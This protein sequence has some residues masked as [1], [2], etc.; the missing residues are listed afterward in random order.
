VVT[1]L[2]N[3]DAITVGSVYLPGS[4]LY[5]SLSAARDQIIA[6]IPFFIGYRYFSSEAHVKDFLYFLVAVVVGYSVLLLFEVRFSPQLHYWVYGYYPSQFAQTIRDGGFRPMAFMGHGLTAAFLVANAA[7]AAATIAR[8]QT[9]SKSSLNHTESKS[10]FNHKPAFVYLNVVLLISKSLAATVYSMALG[11]TV[12]F[13]KAWTTIRIA[14]LLAS[15]ALIY[16]A[17]RM[18]DLFPTTLAVDLASQISD[19]RA[20]SLAFRFANE[21]SLLERAKERSL[22]GWGRYGR[23][24]VFDVDTGKDLTVTDGL[25]IITFGQYGWLGFIGQFGLLSLGIFRAAQA[26]S[27]STR[28]VKVLLAGLATTLAITMINLIPN[29]ALL[30]WTWMIAGCAVGLSEAILTKGSSVLNRP[31]HYIG[32]SRTRSG[33]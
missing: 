13:L 22:Y 24:R 11:S 26:A 5:D 1:G 19:A 29:A 23:N 16:P 20:E 12:L 10:G 3:G 15:V 30:P 4:G 2:F 33:S 25:W 27:R 9:E 6:L 21:D 18:A 8:L 28:D 17:L 31:R 14:C 7:I 32:L